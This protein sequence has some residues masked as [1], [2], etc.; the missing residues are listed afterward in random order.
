ML[1]SIILYSSI[2]KFNVQSFIYLKLNGNSKFHD[3]YQFTDLDNIKVLSL[4]FVDRIV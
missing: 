4:V 2:I 3:K 1:A